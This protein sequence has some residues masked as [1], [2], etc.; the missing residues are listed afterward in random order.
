MATLNEIAYNIK[1]IVEGGVGTDDS[2]LSMRQIKF[3][4][5]TTRASLLLKYTGNGRQTSESVYQIDVLN[6]KSTGVTYK[7][8]VGFNDNKAIRSLAFKSSTAIDEEYEALAIIQNHDRMFVSSSKF[9]VSNSSKYA[10]LAGDKILIFEGSSILGSGKVEMKAIF[11]DPTTVSSYVSDDTTT[12]PIPAELIP[13]LNEEIIG[14]TLNMMYTLGQ[15]QKQPNN[16]TDERTKS[17]KVQ[18]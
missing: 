7:P 15:E 16:Q 17:K 12:Y 8:V 14:K 13:T 18:K 1:N 11:L 4:I 3:L 10:T 9:M 6:P 5:H 2:N